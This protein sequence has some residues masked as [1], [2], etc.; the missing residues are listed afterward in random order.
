MLPVFK[1][2]AADR[3][4]GYHDLE[5]IPWYW[6]GVYQG[7]QAIHFTEN[8][9]GQPVLDVRYSGDGKDAFRMGYNEVWSPFSNP[10][11][12]R[13]DLNKT[14]TS[15]G[16]KLNSLSYGV[17][18]M[19]IYVNTSLNAP[20]SRPTGFSVTAVNGFAQLN[21][22]PNIETDMQYSGK[23][24]IYRAS[25]TGGE[26]T[27]F[28]YM[29]TINAYNGTTPVTSW[30]DVDPVVGGGGLKLF[31]KISAVDN[32][33]LESVLSDYD[34]VPWNGAFQ[35]EG[36]NSEIIISEYKLH[37]NYPNPFNPTTLINYAV[38]EAGLV[39]IKVFDI[40]GSEV[41]SLV[42]ETKE[43]G[44]NSVEFNAASLPSGVYIYT[45]QAGS[46]VSSKKMILLK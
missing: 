22:L 38:K 45:M 17:Y 24:K 33:N 32:G 29:A 39:K 27:T 9:S 25:T 15:F 7:K 2:L 46:F 6:N 34:W 8:K 5:F 36:H 28:Y 40:L 18:S 16:L 20:P 21:W 1:R 11:S 35:K 12:Q 4:N 10:N 41:V 14:A 44:N 43:A 37:N 42:N 30:I 23:Y 31:Y 26:P 3:I 19:D 13:G